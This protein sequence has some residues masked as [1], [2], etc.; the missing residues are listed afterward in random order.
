VCC[1]PVVSPRT[2]RNP[3]PRSRPDTSFLDPS[4]VETAARRT[5]VL[6]EHLGELAAAAQR[7]V[8]RGLEHVVFDD[9]SSHVRLEDPSGR[10]NMPSRR[11][12]AYGKRMGLAFRSHRVDHV[13]GRRG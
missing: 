12:A 3:A 10:A 11:R 1:E 7:V 5:P 13:E 8:E 9:G 2:T 6:D 4:V